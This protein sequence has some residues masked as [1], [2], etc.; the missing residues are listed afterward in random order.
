MINYILTNLLY[1]FAPF[2]NTDGT[3]T[4]RIQITIGIEGDKFGFQQQAT[5]DVIFLTT[6]TVSDV[7]SK[8]QAAAVNY[9]Q[10]T[11]NTPTS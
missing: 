9:V 1:T 6:D 10:N 11:Y 5:F 8:I 2:T 7:Q 4:Q 3:F